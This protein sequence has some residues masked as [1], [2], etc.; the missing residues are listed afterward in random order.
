MLLIRHQEAVKEM[1]WNF[2]SLY[3][4]LIDAGIRG[5][6]YKLNQIRK[7]HKTRFDV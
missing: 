5:Q 2:S 1:S 6:Y 7:E 4:R 3:L